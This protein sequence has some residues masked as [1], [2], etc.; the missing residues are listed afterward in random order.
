MGLGLSQGI[1]LNFLSWAV[2]KKKNIP[3]VEKPW[4]VLPSSAGRHRYRR[5]AAL[6]QT[7]SATLV[8][9]H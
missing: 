9:N 1:S 6:R 3:M 4:N 7:D 5:M 2:R 8:I